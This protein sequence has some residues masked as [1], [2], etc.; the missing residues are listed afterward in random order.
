ML[1]TG[2]R[3]EPSW[4]A[5]F[6]G[7]PGSRYSDTRHHVGFMTAELLSRRLGLKINRIKFKGLWGRAELG[8]KPTVLLLPQTYMNLSGESV[9]EA[10]AFFKI[11]RERIVVVCDDVSLPLGRLRIRARGS[12]GGHNGLKSIISCLGGEDFPRIRIG[13]GAP[14]HPDYDMADWVLGSFT[15]RE[16]DTITAAMDRAGRALECLLEF[17]IDRAM[18]EYNRA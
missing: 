10:A 12:A 1:F 9:Q 13:V 14:P 11:P 5:V 8:G 15:A 7:N 16:A 3:G 4:L 17:G 6:L 2:K 18:S